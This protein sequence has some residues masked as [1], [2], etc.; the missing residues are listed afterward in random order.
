MGCSL[1]EPQ[2]SFPTDL[3]RGTAPYYDRFR[4]PYPEALLDDL[5]RRLPVS[6]TGRLLDLACGTGQI[7]LPLAGR[8]VEVW[9]VDQEPE[10]VAFAKAKAEQD[11]VTKIR[12]SAGAA[13]TVDLDGPFELVAVGNAFHRLDRPVIAR[14]MFSWLEPGGGVA[15]LWGGTPGQGRQSWQRELF[16]LYEEWM[17]KLGVTDRV[18]ASWERVLDRYPHERVL[19]EAGFEYEGKF[20]FAVELTWTVQSL[21]GFSYSTSFLNREV[22]GARVAE[23]EMDLSDR[24]GPHAEGGTFR[25]QTSF[26]YQLARKPSTG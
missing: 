26:T 7:A 23:F 15:L 16:S 13:Q 10:S 1:M 5:C 19:A 22:L 21:A 8:F 3:Y 24:L 12:W 25:E 20:E 4:P 14:R 6:G 18:P 2:F 9:A 17:V 11:G